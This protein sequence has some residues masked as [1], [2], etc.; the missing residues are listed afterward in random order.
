MISQDNV[1]MKPETTPNDIM[2]NLHALLEKATPHE[3]RTISDAM[4]EI[5][6][7]RQLSKKLMRAA[8]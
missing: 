4:Q 8:I 1:V 5:W 6:Y 3:Q 2:L 7:L